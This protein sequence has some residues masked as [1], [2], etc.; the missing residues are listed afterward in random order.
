MD[1]LSIGG[2]VNGNRNV[3]FHVLFNISDNEVLAV[4]TVANSSNFPPLK[5]ECKKR[6][7]SVNRSFL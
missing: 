1:G 4:S 3:F 2:Y 6:F 7:L 5:E